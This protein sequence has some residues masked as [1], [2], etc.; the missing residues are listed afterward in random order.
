MTCQILFLC[1][2]SCLCLPVLGITSETRRGSFHNQQATIP[3]EEDK[4]NQ[5]FNGKQSPPEY[6]VTPADSDIVRLQKQ[7]INYVYS[8][9]KLLRWEVFENP[10]FDNPDAIRQFIDVDSKLYKARLAFCEDPKI[11]LSILEEHLDTAKKME[12]LLKSRLKAEIISP[13]DVAI[14]MHHRMGIELD[15]LKFKESIEK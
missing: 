10:L 11:S 7:R 8:Q 6:R 15:Y 9:W 5:L 14:A 2:L 3:A 4:L 1:G 12:L 13:N